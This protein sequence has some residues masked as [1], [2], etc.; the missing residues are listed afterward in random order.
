MEIQRREQ[1]RLRGIRGASQRGRDKP[2]RKDEQGVPGCWGAQ[3]QEDE[4]AGR[5][6]R[7][8]PQGE[9]RRGDS[10]VRGMAGR[11][12]DRRG[13]DRQQRRRLQGGH[14]A[15]K[16]RPGLRPGSTEEDANIGKMAQGTG[17]QSGAGKG[18]LEA[19]K[20]SGNLLEQSRPE[21]RKGGGKEY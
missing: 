12:G 14:T 17:A 6:G 1:R 8:S 4:T 2:D 16:Q 9:C 21:L 19:R 10:R 3:A 15:F 5:P 20:P 11:V 13:V 7:S 18:A